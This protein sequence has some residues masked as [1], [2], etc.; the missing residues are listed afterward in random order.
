[1]YCFVTNYHEIYNLP[2]KIHIY[3]LTQFLWA[4]HSGAVQLGDSGLGCLRRVQST[5]RLRRQLFEDLT[6]IGGN[7]AMMAHSRSRQVGAGCEKE[8]TVPHCVA[9]L[10][11]WLSILMTWLL[12][13]SERW[14]RTQSES[15]NIFFEDCICLEKFQFHWKIERKIQISAHT[16]CP[17]MHSLPHYQ[18]SS[19]EWCICYN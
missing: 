7:T 14:K 9:N 8:P 19:L 12:P 1:M 11:G 15:H 5:C 3:Y 10:Q 17:H 6:G 2:K 18:H 16:P 13:N 4:R